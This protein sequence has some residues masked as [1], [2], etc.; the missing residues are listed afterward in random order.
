MN[1][2]QLAVTCPNCDETI[3]GNIVADFTNP[4]GVV[5]LDMFACEA[6]VCEKCGTTVCTKLK[7]LTMKAGTKNEVLLRRYRR[8]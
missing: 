5:L 8:R 3:L 2:Y 4:K 7:S 6:F 1:Q